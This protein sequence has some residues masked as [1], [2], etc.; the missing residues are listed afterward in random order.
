MNFAK[1]T[2]GKVT[3]SNSLAFIQSQAE[4]ELSR[5]LNDEEVSYLLAHT[6]SDI[7]HN[8]IE[9]VIDTIFME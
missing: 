6:T 4:L 9:K 5:R 3:K 8:Q 7:L 2:K 1:A